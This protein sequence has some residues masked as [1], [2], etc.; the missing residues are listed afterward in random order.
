MRSD[1][2]TPI[3]SSACR[4]AWWRSSSR[5]SASPREDYVAALQLG[6][7]CTAALDSLFGAAEVVLAPSATG[8]APA[9]ITSTGD[10]V[11]NRPWQLLACPVVHLPYRKGET[12]LPLG[13][14][15]I[16]RPGDDARLLAAAAWIEAKLRD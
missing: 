8:E 12:G 6:R 10:P 1:R 13:I 9:G 5:A 16:A 2:S 11:F 4:R 15:V 3:A 14:S 7:A